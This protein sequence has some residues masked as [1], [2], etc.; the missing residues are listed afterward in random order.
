MNRQKCVLVVGLL[1]I[2]PQASLSSEDSLGQPRF[3]FKIVAGINR[4]TVGDYNTNMSTQYDARKAYAARNGYGFS[5]GYELTHLGLDLEA[6]ASFSLVPRLA[7]VLGTGYIRAG[8]GP[9]AN[10]QTVEYPAYQVTSKFSWDMNMHAVP[11]LLGFRIDI[12]PEGKIGFFLKACFGYFF[13]K[14][15]IISREDQSG[16][17]RGYDWYSY[18]EDGRSGGFGFQGG[19]GFEYRLNRILAFV[20]EGCGRYAKID[21]FKVDYKD[22]YSYGLSRSGSGGLYFY[23]YFDRNTWYPT[24]SVRKDSPTN[25]PNVRNSR[26]AVFDFSGF[27]LRAGIKISL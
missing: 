25:D 10:Q 4:L 14:Y 5:G 19:L 24:M 15:S 17:N 13:A 9:E 6:E 23:E 21:G 11:V 20:I 2:L 7:V 18:E 16:S 8:K 22:A 1:L 3:N 26:Q 27:A 12:L